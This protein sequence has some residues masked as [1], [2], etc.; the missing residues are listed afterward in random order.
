[1][2]LV[3]IAE[4]PFARFFFGIPAWAIGAVIVGIEVLQLLGDRDERA[5]SSC[6]S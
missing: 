4:Y 5:A 2:F 6:C 3:F 1:M